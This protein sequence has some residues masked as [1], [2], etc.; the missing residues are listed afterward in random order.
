MHC[1]YIFTILSLIALISI[2]YIHK[3]KYYYK[4][5][6]ESM[7]ISAVVVVAVT[8]RRC[9]RFADTVVFDF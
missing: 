3:F 1:I 4:I 7:N 9:R 2:N 8:V 5:T 6:S